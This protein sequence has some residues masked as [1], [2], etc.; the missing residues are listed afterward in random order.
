M[1]KLGWDFPHFFQFLFPTVITCL[2]PT[3]TGLFGQRVSRG[4]GGGRA[5][6]FVCKVRVLKFGTQLKWINLP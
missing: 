3:R 1:R 4:T 2:N 5:Y 6:S